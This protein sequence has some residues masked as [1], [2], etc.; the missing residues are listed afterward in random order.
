MRFWLD[1]EVSSNHSVNEWQY[2]CVHTGC[3]DAKEANQQKDGCMTWDRMGR[4]TPSPGTPE[5]GSRITSDLVYKF[6]VFSAISNRRVCGGL[7]HC[8]QLWNKHHTAK[9]PLREY[10]TH[11][12]N[13]LVHT[14]NANSLSSTYT[15]RIFTCKVKHAHNA[16][17]R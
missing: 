16:V 8:S 7:R 11:P 5:G 4:E 2:K 15:D 1:L 12:A 17:A 6:Y 13:K 3:L 9:L 14:M 10:H